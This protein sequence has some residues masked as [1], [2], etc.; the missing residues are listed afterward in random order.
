[1]PYVKKRATSHKS[2]YGR[3]RRG[4]SNVYSKRMT[5][6][7]AVG[8]T[9]RTSKTRDTA[10]FDQ[11][12]LVF[13]VS[14]QPTSDSFSV[15][16]FAVN[17]GLSSLFPILSRNAQCYTRYKMRFNIEFVS[18]V[19]TAATGNILIAIDRNRSE[20]PPVSVNRMMSY[21]GAVQSNIWSTACY[22]TNRSMIRPSEKMLYTRYGSILPGE[23]INLY[24]MCNVFIGLTG[25]DS[26]AFPAGTSIG[27]IYIT[28]QCKFYDQ[29]V[30]DI[31]DNNAFVYYPSYDD[32]ALETIPNNA[33][34]L[35]PYVLGRGDVQYT[36]S[37]ARTSPAFGGAEAPGVTLVFP[38]AGFYLIEQ[39]AFA[40]L[41]P[42]AT[43]SPSA[44]FSLQ[45][46]GGVAA[47]GD[48]LETAAMD[49]SYGTGLIASPFIA[50]A[51][52]AQ[53]ASA[54]GVSV[55]T[56]QI[57]QVLANGT[58]IVGDNIVIGDAWISKTV[59]LAAFAGTLSN[60]TNEVQI[61]NH[62]NSGI[63]TA[64]LQNIYIEVSPV[65]IETAAY[66]YP[67]VWQSN[68][69]SA[70]PL[71]VMTV[72]Q[73]R[74]HQAFSG[75]PHQHAV[76]SGGA[77]SSS[78]ASSGASAASILSQFKSE[79]FYEQFKAI[80]EEME[81]INDRIEMLREIPLKLRPDDY[82]EQK[83]MFKRDLAGCR[84]RL[85]RLVKK[86]LLKDKN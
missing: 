16:S 75:I 30:E 58:Y 35:L 26:T 48:P 7:V 82:S 1:M 32:D 64:T 61:F 15:V 53:G 63:F 31:I 5:A 76:S 81:E 74:H 45:P 12:E 21:A 24:D 36:G 11:R 14:T 20:G 43:A 9:M 52:F 10:S 33:E 25:V 72:K 57:V 73:H 37:V 6:P 40:Q 83:T 79:L 84:E 42:V 34:T 86:N 29:R 85:N 38:S 59:G 19:G 4:Y 50:T 66:F 41:A 49:G 77:S 28:Y 70:G 71:T 2:Y 23:D 47:D 39:S 22:P 3:S 80:E 78:G 51:A 55:R 60:A 27:Q 69:Q 67:T 17:P 56:T 68:I 13:S 44:P 62:E 54:T 65:D 8:T 46:F 18:S